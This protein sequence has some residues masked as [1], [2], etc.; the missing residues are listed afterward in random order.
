[1]TNLILVFDK[2]ELGATVKDT[3]GAFVALLV[4]GMDKKWGLFNL[5]EN[6]YTNE[7]SSIISRM[8]GE[9]END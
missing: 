7:V 9:P 6:R 3:N 5:L 1:M 8:N 2:R 4:Y